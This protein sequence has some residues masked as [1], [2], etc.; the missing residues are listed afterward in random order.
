MKAILLFCLLLVFNAAA[1]EKRYRVPDTVPANADSLATW[2]N[3]NC[4]DEREK[5]ATL[6]SWMS[7]HIRYDLK[8][9]YSMKNQVRGLD[10]MGLVNHVLTSGKAVCS[11][12]ACTFIA[13]AKRMDIPALYVIG[14]CFDP[15]KKMI[16]SSHAWVAVKTS[17]GWSLVDPTWGAGG[18][19]VNHRKFLWWW[20]KKVYYLEG[21]DWRYFMQPNEVFIND[22]VPYDP[23]YQFTAYPVSN[24][25]IRKK[26][27]RADSTLPAFAFN[28]TLRYYNNLR[29]ADASQNSIAR[30]R[31]YGTAN[32]LVSRHINYLRSNLPF[33]QMEDDK[34]SGHYTKYIDTRLQLNKLQADYANIQQATNAGEVI[35]PD[36]AGRLLA[37]QTAT[38]SLEQAMAGIVITYTE[39]KY[40]LMANLREVRFLQKQI[41]RQQLYA[42]KKIETIR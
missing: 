34:N 24:D 1:Q 9:M 13:V 21:L 5:L 3:K 28:D 42:R 17:T 30:I 2:I 41:L 26:N 20:Y 36:V 37:L 7:S 4:T 39:V 19:I 27:R 29:N 12:F 31:R 40:K 22:H 35:W 32:H 15:R 38:D 33:W 18:T 23:L 14:Y 16:D 8:G 11:G 10:T 6:Y 25:S